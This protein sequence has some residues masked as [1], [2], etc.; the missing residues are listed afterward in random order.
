VTAVDGGGPEILL[1]A[2]IN[3]FFVELEID[4]GSP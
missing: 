3:N 4:G 2:E 1:L